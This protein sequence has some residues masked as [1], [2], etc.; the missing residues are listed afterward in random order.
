MPHIRYEV[1]E[2]R[3]GEEY[4]LGRK[5]DKVRFLSYAADLNS[6]RHIMD[7][8]WRRLGRPIAVYGPTGLEILRERKADG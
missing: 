2:C 8:A 7:E 4:A 1:W 5:L 3:R 6:A